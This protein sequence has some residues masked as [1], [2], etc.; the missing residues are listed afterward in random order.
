M[1]Q[2]NLHPPELFFSFYA[3]SVDKMVRGEGTLESS[4]MGD[5]YRGT[6]HIKLF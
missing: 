6:M 4:D 1:Y 3:T 2:V 5:D